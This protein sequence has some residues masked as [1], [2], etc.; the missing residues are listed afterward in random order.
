M[1]LSAL[2]LVTTLAAAAD[3]PGVVDSYLERHFEM[4]PSRATAAGRRGL[5]GQLE[6]LSPERRQAW[7]SFNEQT[8]DSLEQLLMLDRL[9]YEDRID[10]E[11]LLAHV[12]RE[13]HD[14]R[15]LRRLD[16]D[17]LAWTGIAANAT[18][19]LLLRE[20]QP[21]E[22]RLSAARERALQIPRL[23]RQARQA[24]GATDPS[25][26]VPE[27]ARLAAGQA[28]RSAVFF[29]DGL[30][31]ASGDEETSAAL[32]EAGGQAAAALSELSSFLERLADTAS[33]PPR[34]GALYPSALRL[35]L[36]RD[37]APDDVLTAAEQDL[38]DIHGEAAG[39]GR[40]VWAELMTGDVP[41][42]DGE[43]LRALFRRVEDDHASEL[44]E[45]VE[46]WRETTRE[47][48]SFVRDN[49]IIG[50]P[51]PLTLLIGPSPAYFIGQSV[52]G[53]YS[54]GPYAPEAK[55]L[56]LLPTPPVDASPEQR[57]RLFRAFNDHFNR[58]I[59][60]HELIPGHYLQLKWAARH[61]HRVRALFADPVYV[62]GWG[63]FCERLLLDEG[64]GDPLARL[65]HLKK[66]LENA[67]R[68]I[69][70][71][72]VHT[73][74]AT[75]EEVVAFLRDD[76]VQDPQ[77]ASNM[78][79]RAITSSPQLL[80]YH[81]GYREVRGL[82]EGFRQAR[83]EGFELRDFMDWMM[84]L[85]PV[86]LRHYRERLTTTDGQRMPRRHGEHGGGP[87]D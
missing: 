66:Q 70:D 77:L 71:I 14:H 40:K 3:V 7:V 36:D 49:D 25:E 32:A 62:E 30:A 38:S 57:E 84:E 39:Y 59:A 16:R 80:T 37:L 54:A 51:D 19:Y 46:A 44:G 26:I 29:T 9:A 78:W 42:D 87:E 23:T 13:I 72:R 68:T 6:N 21:L 34:L 63:T 79:R 27:L 56:L 20:D 69:V 35:G 33:C 2:L 82:Y 76:A 48:E 12:R 5:D 18:V 75:R 28:S 65:A 43:L 50:L 22:A 60:P 15:I 86:N 17:P 52:G 8:R 24:L 67:A 45:Y 47:L 81:L 1:Q 64:W 85:G 55:T 31:G 4:H 10:A 53:V 58:M 41:A 61:P 74:G 83:G 11:V 73:K